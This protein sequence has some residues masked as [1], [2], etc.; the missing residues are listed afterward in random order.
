MITTYNSNIKA[1]DLAGYKRKSRIN[2][3]VYY[4]GFCVCL[5][6]CMYMSECV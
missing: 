4:T 1:D 6:D 3:G 2:P 5:D